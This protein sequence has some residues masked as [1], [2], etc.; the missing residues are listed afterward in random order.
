MSSV[1]FSST[2]SD[3]QLLE[4][5]GGVLADERQ[6][7][8]RSVVDLTSATIELPPCISIII[9]LVDTDIPIYI[10]TLSAMLPVIYVLASGF[11]CYDGAVD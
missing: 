9:V 8:I 1:V 10:L 2:E 11:I 6:V 5:C 3:D 7:S 4:H